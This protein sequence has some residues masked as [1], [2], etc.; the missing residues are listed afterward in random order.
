[1]S[2]VIVL[3]EKQLAVTLVLHLTPPPLYT[4]TDTHDVMVPVTLHSRH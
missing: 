1:V 2:N 4:P 3:S